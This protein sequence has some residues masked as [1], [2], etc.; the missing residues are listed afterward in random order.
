M[1]IVMIRPSPVS[2]FRSTGLCAAALCLACVTSVWAQEAKPTEV[3]DAWP[4][5]APVFP[6]TGGNGIMIEGYDPVVANG[7]CST[8]FVARTP[9]GAAYANMVVFDAI[10]TQGGI[11]CSNGRWRAKDGSASGATPFRV[12]IKDGVK[13]GSP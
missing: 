4:V 9:D 5:L 3:Y 10:P 2:A 11:L 6:S 1:E 7:L 12:F 13:R 8:D